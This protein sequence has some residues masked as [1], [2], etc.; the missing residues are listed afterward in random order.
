MAHS[1]DSLALTLLVDATAE[2]ARA[3][4]Q[5]IRHRRE[6]ETR[7]QILA[8]A[9]RRRQGGTQAFMLAAFL[10]VTVLAPFLIGHFVLTKTFVLE[11]DPAVYYDEVRGISDHFLATYFAGLI[12]IAAAL[13]LFL[14]ARQPWQGRTVAVSAGWIAL[15]GSVVILLPAAQSQ[16]HDAEQKTVA[17]LRETAFPFDDRYYHCASWEIHAENGIQQPELWQVH[18]GRLKGS[19]VD[20]CNRVNVYRGWQLVG[21]YNLPDGDTFT[22]DVVINHVGWDSPYEASGSG[23]VWSENSSTGVQVPMNPVATNVDLG[24]MSGRRL[25]FSLDGAGSDQFELR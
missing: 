14:V 19:D 2:S 13:G 5:S 17:K 16:W 25:N 20:G 8:A 24:T 15:L 18:L 3:Q 21:V 7:Q 11:P 4:G 22:G 23:E 9:R 10:A 6:E 12:P 1:N